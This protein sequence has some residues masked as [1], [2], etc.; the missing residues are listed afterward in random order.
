MHNDNYD[1]YLIDLSLPDGSGLD[2]LKLAEIESS[3]KPL[4]VMTGIGESDVDGQAMSLGAT[5]FLHKSEIE[6]DQLIRRLRYAIQ[7]K[8]YEM[9]LKH[10]AN[11]DRLTG[12]AQAH[13]FREETER[14][15]ARHLRLVHIWR[16][17][18]W[19]SMALNR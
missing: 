15:V 17:C 2:L 5:D 7:R 12:L 14:A 3:S 10:Y 16:Y 18:C 11:H 4:V 8:H 13:Y 1:L 9:S 6:N 19:I